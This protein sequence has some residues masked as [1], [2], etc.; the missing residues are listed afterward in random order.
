MKYNKKSEINKN[1][2]QKTLKFA[3]LNWVYRYF[4]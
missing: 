3:K 2:E 4:I 1:R